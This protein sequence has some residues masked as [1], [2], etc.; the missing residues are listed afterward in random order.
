MNISRF[1]LIIFTE[2]REFYGVSNI[3]VKFAYFLK[4]EG[5]IFWILLI[6]R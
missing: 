4:G 2:E 3:C 1:L 5:N 6:N